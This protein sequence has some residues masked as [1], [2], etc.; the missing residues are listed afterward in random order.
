M[1]G[2]LL[3]KQITIGLEDES[4]LARPRFGLLYFPETNQLNRIVAGSSQIQ[5]FT[6]NQALYWGYV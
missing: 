1:A 2:G 3:L 6:V 4:K 5:P